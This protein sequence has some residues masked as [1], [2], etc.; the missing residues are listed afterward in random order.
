MDLKWQ[1]VLLL[2]VKIKILLNDALSESVK[3]CSSSF[4]NPL[5]LIV[6]IKGILQIAKVSLLCF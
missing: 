4:E 3:F 2:L 1:K 5:T 6:I